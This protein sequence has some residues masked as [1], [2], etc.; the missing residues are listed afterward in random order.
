MSRRKWVLHQEALRMWERCE[1]ARSAWPVGHTTRAE[2]SQRRSMPQAITGAQ[3]GGVF[4]CVHMQAHRQTHTP[5]A[6]MLCRFSATPWTVAHQAPLSKGFSRQGYWSELSC[7]PPGGL[8]NPGIKSSP[9]TSPAL[10]GGFST[11]SATWEAHTPLT[12]PQ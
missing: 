4:M 7:R 5:P 11:T 9:L 12:S 3:E 2:Q 8:P 6:C 10:A 1:T